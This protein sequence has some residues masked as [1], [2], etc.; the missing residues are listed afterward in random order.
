[1]ENKIYLKMQTNRSTQYKENLSNVN[2]GI[3]FNGKDFEFGIC[4]TKYW[5]NFE[6]REIPLALLEIEGTQYKIPLD[7]LIK[8]IKPMLKKFKA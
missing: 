8:N 3:V 6:G 5:G 7:T 2:T 4:A 1:M